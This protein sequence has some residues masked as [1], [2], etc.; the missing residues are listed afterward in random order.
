[1]FRNEYYA[2][3]KNYEQ[4][5][6]YVKCL[7]TQNW[8]LVTKID[9]LNQI[10]SRFNQKTEQAESTLLYANKGTKQALNRIHEDANKRNDRIYGNKNV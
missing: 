10:A 4:S 1:M 3:K 2:Y 9:R 5:Q 6:E 8:Q 7:E